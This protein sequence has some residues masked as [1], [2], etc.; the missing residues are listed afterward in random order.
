MSTPFLSIRVAAVCLSL[1]GEYLLLR[2]GRVERWQISA[3]GLTC[4]ETILED[5][6]LYNIFFSRVKG[7][8]VLCAVKKKEF[9][10]IRDFLD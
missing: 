10:V 1:C 6:E 5:Q 2:D 4:C 9:Y 7:E 8:P 3:D